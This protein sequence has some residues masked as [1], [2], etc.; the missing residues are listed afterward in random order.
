YFHPRRAQLRRHLST[1]P[2]VRP[3][4]SNTRRN[5]ANSASALLS[6]VSLPFLMSADAVGEPF[7][8]GFRHLWSP[9]HP[10]SLPSSPFPMLLW[11]QLHASSTH[12]S[13]SQELLQVLGN[14]VAT[15]AT[16]NC[17]RATAT[18]SAQQQLS[19]RNSNCLRATATVSAQQQLSPRNSNCL[20]ATP[21][22]NIEQERRTPADTRAPSWTGTGGGDVERRRRAMLHTCVFNP[23]LRVLN[24]LRST[25]NGHKSTRM[26]AFFPRRV[27]LADDQSAGRCDE[28]LSDGHGERSILSRTLLYC[29]VNTM[30][31]LR[32]PNRRRANRRHA[33]AG[34]F[35]SI[36]HGR[37][38]QGRTG[39]DADVWDADADAG[40]DG[41]VSR[42]Y[43]CRVPI[44]AVL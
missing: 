8:A 32:K 15:R 5:R 18:V 9:P 33:A 44:G 25:T 37:W 29:R 22:P 28:S 30:A 34:L 27:P 38:A 7:R 35:G 17:L 19:P 1:R 13:S 11:L 23:H 16:S 40:Q 21:M 42:A 31:V 24:M 10:P 36:Q 26:K 39:R 14:P 20:R 4:T 3:C 41:D 2:F 6:A 12:A 43:L